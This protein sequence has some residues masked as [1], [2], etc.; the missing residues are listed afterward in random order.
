MNT[1]D[2]KSGVLPRPAVSS[3]ASHNASHRLIRIPINR[4]KSVWTGIK[5]GTGYATK[6]PEWSSSMLDV[7][8]HE[9]STTAE[10][11]DADT[12]MD[13]LAWISGQNGENNLSLI[14]VERDSSNAS[15]ASP[16]GPTSSQDNLHSTQDMTK[17]NKLKIANDHTYRLK[18]YD[19]PSVQTY[20]RGPLLT[21]FFWLRYRLFPWFRR[22]FLRYS[23]PEFN[24]PKVER[25]YSDRVYDSQKVISITPHLSLLL[26]VSQFLAFV[27]SSWLVISWAIA[28]T[29]L[30]S[31]TL[32]SDVIFYYCIAPVLTVPLPIMIFYDL[33]K[34]LPILYQC[35]L[36]I[37]IWSWS[38][39][40]VLLQCYLNLTRAQCLSYRLYA[41]MQ[42]L[43]GSPR[44]PRLFRS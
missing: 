6:Q 18:G 44:L 10:D 28:L 37:S 2:P 11:G 32:I 16:M 43:W 30:P 8:D 35:Y 36:V 24:D 21:P 42:L 14:L 27:C 19:Q 17:S 5:N 22:A 12:D 40:P 41:V 13:E 15:Q 29:L 38:Y 9:K 20:R 3:P 26:T 39:V 23:Y 4:W 34:R 33:P 25:T 7:S 1:F 31:H